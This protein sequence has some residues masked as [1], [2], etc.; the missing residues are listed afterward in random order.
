VAAALLA[1][2]VMGI[3][4][5]FVQPHSSTANGPDGPTTAATSQGNRPLHLRKPSPQASQAAVYDRAVLDLMDR[6]SYIARGGGKKEVALTFDDGP[7]PSTPAIR[8][9]LL[10]HHVPATFF[11]IGR[12]AEASPKQVRREIAQ[13]FVVGNHT[14]D[15][16]F[17]GRIAASTQDTELRTATAAI[18]RGGAPRPILFRPP[19]G[20]FAPSTLE[21]LRQQKM[22]MVLWSVDTKDFERPG[23]NV[24]VYRALSGATPGAIILMHDGGGDRSQTLAALPRIIK[25]LRKRGYKLVS[26]PQMIHDDPPR[27]QPAPRPLDGSHG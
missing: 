20:S 16:A 18:E 27:H 21:L 13:G 25:G 15:H 2:G 3:V 12:E 9:L 23:T 6:T 10:R 17:M 5:L 26:V 22:L 14:W 7:G 24:V 1:G 19:Y 4:S 8:A 11:M